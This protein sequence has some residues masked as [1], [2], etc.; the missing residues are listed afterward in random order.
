MVCTP[1]RNEEG[2][3]PQYHYQRPRV[4]QRVEELS[5]AFSSYSAVNVSK[6]DVG[7]FYPNI[8]LH[9]ALGLVHLRYYESSKW[10]FVMSHS[11]ES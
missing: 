11:D 9:R 5:L 8:F 7:R 4:Y 3:I 10:R 2:G 1:P 6:C